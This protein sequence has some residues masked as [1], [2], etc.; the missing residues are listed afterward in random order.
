M[1]SKAFS[2][3]FSTMPAMPRPPMFPAPRSLRP[4]ARA[5]TTSHS[6]PNAPRRF[7]RPRS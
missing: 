2:K 5:F 3:M 7:A 1:F 4:A 6:I